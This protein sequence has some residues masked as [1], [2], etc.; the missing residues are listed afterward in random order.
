MIH[1]IMA[2]DLE[3]AF[4]VPVAKDGMLQIHKE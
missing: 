3:F 1:N 2:G 4:A